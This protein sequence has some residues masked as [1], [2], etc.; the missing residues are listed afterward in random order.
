MASK[1]EKDL[2]KQRLLAQRKKN[3]REALTARRCNAVEGFRRACDARNIDTTHQQPP[4][5]WA[6][7]GN[8]TR[9]ETAE[10]DRQLRNYSPHDEVAADSF[11]QRTEQPSL[12]TYPPKFDIAPAAA[13]SDGI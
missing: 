6:A 11:R 5:W 3:L 10:V 9:A 1:R 8:K 12:N 4:K 13:V 2:E 7:F